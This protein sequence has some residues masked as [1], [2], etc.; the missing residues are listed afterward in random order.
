M[1]TNQQWTDRL[2]RQW[3]ELRRQEM[4]LSLYIEDGLGDDFCYDTLEKRASD[5]ARSV[6]DAPAPSMLAHARNVKHSSPSL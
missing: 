5:Y 6:R 2:D 4:I 3:A 1:L